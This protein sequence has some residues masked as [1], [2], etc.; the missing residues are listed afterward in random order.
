MLIGRDLSG[1]NGV[2]RAVC[3]NGPLDMPRKRDHERVNY[4]VLIEKKCLVRLL[5]SR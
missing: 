2:E 4:P 1:L 3:P 5:Y